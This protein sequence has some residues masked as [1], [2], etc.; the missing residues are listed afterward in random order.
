[1]KLH[2]GL[3]FVLAAA[4]FLPCAA[5][6]QTTTTL[7]LSSNLNPSVVGEQVSVVALVSGVGP[8][9][10]VQFMDGATKLGTP[11]T[12]LLC[13]F[14]P[15]PPNGCSAE[16]S[17]AVIQTST[18]TQGVH[19]IT[20]TYSG[21]RQNAPSSGALVQNVTAVGSLSLAA[22]PTL[23]SWG[24]SNAGASSCTRR[25]KGCLFPL[26]LAW[27]TIRSSGRLLISCRE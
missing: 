10:T 17:V 16:P 9:G 24:G 25:K 1:M 26:A 3:L 23:S 21:D 19:S 8:T 6:A 18:L 22:I 2:A 14:S 7:E 15:I 5:M 20:A 13:Q 27:L 4:I 12:L 11:I